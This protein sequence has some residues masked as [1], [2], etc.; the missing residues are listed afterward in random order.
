MLDLDTTA[1]NH[2][3][4]YMRDIEA[5]ARHHKRPSHTLR[6]LNFVAVVAIVVYLAVRFIAWVVHQ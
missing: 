6:L 1:R 3:G 2:E 4:D 5:Q